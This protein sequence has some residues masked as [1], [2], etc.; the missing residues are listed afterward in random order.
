MLRLLQSGLLMDDLL[1]QST[2]KLSKLESFTCHRLIDNKEITISS[3][4]FWDQLNYHLIHLLDFLPSSSWKLHVDDNFLRSFTD[5]HKILLSNNKLL[6][7]VDYDA[8]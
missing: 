5:L 1:S 2:E 4:I 3:E 8:E 6:C 7:T